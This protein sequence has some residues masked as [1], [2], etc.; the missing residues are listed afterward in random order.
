MSAKYTLA[1]GS[2]KI[3]INFAVFLWVLICIIA[4]YVGSMYAAFNVIGWYA[5][6]F[7][8][9]IPIEINNMSLNPWPKYVEAALWIALIALAITYLVIL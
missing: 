1:I 9:I 3:K 7:S 5:L 8:T 4:L 6:I 2:K